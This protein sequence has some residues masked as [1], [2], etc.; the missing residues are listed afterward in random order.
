MEG[1]WSGLANWHASSLRTT[2]TVTN[3]SF[4]TLN[5]RNKR[6]QFTSMAVVKTHNRFGNISL[7]S[8]H[9]TT[10]FMSSAARYWDHFL[11][12]QHSHFRC[13]FRCNWERPFV[14]VCL[15]I[16]FAEN[17]AHNP[18]RAYKSSMPLDLITPQLSR[19]CFKKVRISLSAQRSQASEQEQICSERSSIVAST[20]RDYTENVRQFYG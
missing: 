14:F 8:L 1:D 4:P 7:A 3:N 20:F 5:G 11:H 17:S 19:P 12:R 2:T 15:K 13:N 16:E 10:F 18:H 9:T 6:Q